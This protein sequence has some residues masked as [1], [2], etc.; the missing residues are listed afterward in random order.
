MAKSATIAVAQRA[1]V[2]AGKKFANDV[3]SLTA[4]Q[5]MS[6]LVVRASDTTIKK[7]AKTLKV[8]LPSKPKTSASKGNRTAMWIG[9]DEWL[10]IDA[11]TEVKPILAKPNDTNYSAADIS[12]RNTAIEISGPGAENVLAAGCA[13]NMALDVFPVGACSHTVYGKAEI[14]VWRKDELTFHVECWRS[15]ADYVW[16]FL[17]DAAK[18]AAA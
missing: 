2:L 8:S 14:V 17:V 11:S 4:L 18:D 12:H 15:F 13:Q 7:L 5:P 10:V 3:V 9:P 1:P 16:G 6:R